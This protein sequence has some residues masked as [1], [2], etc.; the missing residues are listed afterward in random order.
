MI[1]VSIAETHRFGRVRRNGYNPAEV[2]AVVAR[3]IEVLRRNDE[4]ITAL[5]ERINV[6]D[7]S[8][9]AIRRTFEAAEA[10]RDE[11]ISDA[12]TEATTIADQARSEAEDLVE[13]ITEMRSEIAARRQSILTE[14][15]EDAE[16]RMLTIE[17]QTAQ[18][19]TDA[20][21]AIR[22]AIDMRNRT[23]SDTEAEA[24]VIRHR[25]EEEAAQIRARITAMAQAAAALE[26]AAGALA[27][28]AQDGARVIDLTAI[29][30][31]DQ[32]GLAA[33]APAMIVLPKIVAEDKPL[34]VAP[35][36]TEDTVEEDKMPRTRYQRTTGIPLKERIKIA[37]MSG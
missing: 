4:R 2:D 14:V 34:L 22:D 26:T 23:V 37:R 35:D 31:L 30:H 1:T 28:S 33:S 17:Q 32:R 11:I 8:V 18:R 5:M 24:E 13:S 36:S 3:L 19:S 9:D 7:G 20:E 6:A 27:A 21:W 12:E 25:A 15:Y 10:T 29:E 16:D